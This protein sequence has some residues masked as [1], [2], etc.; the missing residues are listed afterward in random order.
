MFWWLGTPGEPI[1][2]LN[3][4]NNFHPAIKFT[5]E[6]SFTTRSVIFLDLTIWVD[7]DGYIQTDLHTKENAKNSYL[8]PSSNHPSHI[9][10]NITYS[11]A[12]R[13]MRN[14]SHVERRELKFQELSDRLVARGY[15]RKAVE[16]AI[17]KVRKL[18]RELMLE[19]V[20]RE[21]DSSVDR[22]RAIFSS[23]LT[24]R[25]PNLSGIRRIGKPWLQM[26]KDC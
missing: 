26:T 24:L 4:V 21:E 9:T 19:R 25:L 8:L 5:W 22:V 12:F 16:S 1:I 7:E 10:K 3:F 14:C 15:R 13:I 6:Y 23:G 18:D 17:D 2:F 11:L 20:V